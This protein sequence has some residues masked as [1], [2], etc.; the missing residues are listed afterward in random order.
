MHSTGRSS[1]ALLGLLMVL[2]TKVGAF[3]QT[4]IIRPSPS[5]SPKSCFLRR[6]NLCPL[7]TS[8]TTPAT[9]I[10]YN[11][12]NDSI[13][14]FTPSPNDETLTDLV[15][16]IDDKQLT[17]EEYLARNSGCMPYDDC[18]ET[19]L[20]A[21]YLMLPQHSN[22]GVNRILSSTESFLQALHRKSKRIEKDQVEASKEAGQATEYVFA[23]NYV[24][25]GKI[26]TVG[27]DYDY[28]LVTYTEEL[29]ELIYEKALAR[30]VGQRQYPSEM[31][32][33]GLAYD[34]FFSIRGLAVDKEK[35]WITHLSYTHKVAV[36]W[37]GREKLPTSRL[38][39]EYRV[40]RALNP[41]DRKNRLKPLNDLFSMAEC[42]LIADT[43]QF[44]KDRD[45]P[46]SPR[47]VVNDVLKAVTDT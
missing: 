7:Y 45:I 14:E 28:T 39:Q 27:F 11:D 3:F 15:P 2:K 47:N 40:K 30:L 13:D 44:F 22:E 19:C 32:E 4:Q 42:C 10:N 33:A 8:A 5:F 46:F 35:G 21:A 17:N 26:D 31:L 6:K 38:F 29:L 41:Q 37:E 18:T 34:P 1:A 36:A 16:D 12:T 9:K 20:P 24:N 23:N 25:V 43:V